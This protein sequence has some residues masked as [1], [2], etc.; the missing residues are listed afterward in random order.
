[1]ARLTA[2]DRGSASSRVQNTGTSNTLLFNGSNSVV[3]ADISNVLSS[4]TTPFT[5]I[6]WVY[7]SRSTSA[8][9]FE[10]SNT[11][12]FTYDATTRVLVASLFFSTT[13]A[14][15]ES[16]G[17]P[18]YFG[19]WYRVG[20][21]S[22]GTTAPP[23]VYLNGANVGTVIDTSVGTS[24]P[25]ISNMYIGNRAALNR[26]LAGNQSGVLLYGRQ[27]SDVEMARD[28]TNSL[29]F[30]G[31]IGRWNLDEGS[32]TT[33]IDTSGSG[34]NGTISNGTWST[35]VPFASRSILTSDRAQVV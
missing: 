26:P 24:T 13:A 9:F 21:S 22:D 20:M 29:V 3:T 11:T 10:F 6:S 1:M 8:R 34:N 25:S 14:R 31:L 15:T 5:Y 17:F 7:I 33:A 18:I 35:N 12:F 27:L 19:P 30:N 32:G 16:T 2:S 23:K 28:Y 4:S